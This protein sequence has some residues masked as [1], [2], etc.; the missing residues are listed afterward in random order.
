MRRFVLIPLWALAVC[1]AS[2]T[3]DAACDPKLKKTKAAP[4]VVVAPQAPAPVVR[5]DAITVV[6]ALRTTVSTRPVEVVL[7]P[8]QAGART[9]VV[10]CDP[11]NKTKSRSVT[12]SSTGCDPKTGATGHGVTHSQRA[13][14][15]PATPPTPVAPACPPS[16]QC[17]PAPACAPTQAV[18][19]APAPHGMPAPAPT[20]KKAKLRE[21]VDALQSPDAG[22]P[23]VASAQHGLTRVSQASPAQ[24]GHDEHAEHSGCEGEAD[25]EHVRRD[26]EQARRDQEQA[27]RDQEQARRDQEQALREHE[28]SVREAE[29]ERREAE[30]EAREALEEA[31]QAIDEARREAE[32][33]RREALTEARE[34]IEE[35]RREAEEVRRE[36]LE[37]AREAL[38]EVRVNG[39]AGLEGLE[40]LKALEGLQG[41]EGLEELE[42]LDES[43]AEELESHEGLFDESTQR[44]LAETLAQVHGQLP[45]ALAQSSNGLFARQQQQRSLEDRVAELERIAGKQG[46]GS[47]SIEERVAELERMLKQGGGAPKAKMPKP[48]KEPKAPKPPK[49]KAKAQGGD[50]HDEDDTVEVHPYVM[51]P[52][53]GGLFRF[54]ND[55]QNGWRVERDGDQWKVKTWADGDWKELPQGQRWKIEGEGDTRRLQRWEDGEWK[56]FEVPHGV[57]RFVLPRDAHRQGAAPKV[58]AEQRARARAD[59]SR[60]RS[61]SA[62]RTPPA[63]AERRRDLEQLMQQMKREVE[64]MREEMERLRA[65]LRE[66]PNTAR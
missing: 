4:S 64:T 65:E 23:V 33:E 42:H 21:L 7:A 13:V 25:D 56:T 49:S 41:L 11:K 63:D 66:L 45:L 35:A 22:T 61:R 18:P 60:E 39:V 46:D 24:H 37:D 32:E 12:V 3:A 6:P 19:A 20:A 57:Q 2:R 53:Q 54:Q 47:Q 14:A 43:I 29:Q 58:E 48:P 62:Q 28:Q 51:H 27:H 50:D 17:A 40:G 59:E 30:Q 5:P 38:R 9:L 8:A 31:R 1:A 26:H 36:A 15:A 44:A 16:P 55:G 10:A 34:A 52:G